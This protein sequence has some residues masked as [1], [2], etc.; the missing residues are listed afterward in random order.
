MA[1]IELHTWTT[2]NGYKP[3]ILL[4][5]LGA[6]YELR[7][8]RIGAGEQKRPEYLKLNPNGRIP[9]LVDRRGGET[10]T[11]FES[12]AILIHL[13]ERA[14]AFLAKGG[15]ARADALAWLMFQMSAVGPM[16]GQLGYFSRAQGEQRSDAAI[17]R[18]KAES[19]RIL[20]VLERRLGEAKFLAGEYSIADVATYPWTRNLGMLGASSEAYPNVARWIEEVGARP[21]VQKA[22]AVRM[23][24]A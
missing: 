8:V 17:A 5:E 22:L 19:E 23:D 12:G 20:G 1:D 2:P 9:A 18:F 15:Q 16:F 11:V 21:A 3:V 7:P 13:A 10:V 6:A 24:A 14:G 4:E